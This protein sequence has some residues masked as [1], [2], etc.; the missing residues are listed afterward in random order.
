MYYGFITICPSTGDATG[1]I[2]N[3]A[4]TLPRSVNSGLVVVKGSYNEVKQTL[5]NRL[6]HGAAI[7]AK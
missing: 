3:G 7:E 2:Y 4:Q 5:I 6:P 1:Q